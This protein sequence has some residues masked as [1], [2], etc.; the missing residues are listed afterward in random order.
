MAAL[1]GLV[2]FMGVLLLAG[3]GLLGWGMW[4]KAHK[5]G[6]APA[7]V[8]GESGGFGTVEVPL[9]AGARVEQTLVAGDRVVLR[10]AG[11]GGPERLVVL[12]PGQGR[13]V[14]SFEMAPQ[15]PS[16]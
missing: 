13:V 10:V 8:A 11:G 15:P 12:D 6:G 1:K 5:V 7:T 3:L 4:S 16:R 14:G 2:A 9:P